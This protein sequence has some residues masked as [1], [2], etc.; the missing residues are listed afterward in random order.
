MNEVIYYNYSFVKKKIINEEKIEKALWFCMVNEDSEEYI[1]KTNQAHDKIYRIILGNK[2]EAANF[3]NK[4][5][6]LKKFPLSSKDIEKYST[7]FITND[8]KSK[9]SDIIYKKKGEDIFFLIEHQSSVDY[10]MAY[11]L[12]NY[13][14]EIIRSAIDEKKLGNKD[15][16]IPVVYPIVLYTGEKKWNAKKYLQEN[17]LKLK[18][19]KNIGITNYAITDISKC[20]EKDLM[21][22]KSF[23]SKILLLDKSRTNE[24][25]N[26]NLNKIIK[27]EM[28]NEEKTVLKQVIYYTLAKKIGEDVA[29]KYIE[30]LEY[31]EE[32]K[33][34]VFEEYLEKIIDEGLEKG[35]Q[36]GMKQGMKQ[37]IKEG[38]E[39]GKKENTYNIVIEMI[40]NNIDEAKIKL[41]TK[42][43][44]KEFQNIKA[45]MIKNNIKNNCIKTTN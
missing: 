3:I 30:K 41:I 26:Q 31:K 16:K 13:S 44:E 42:I 2:E 10:S 29:K 4:N 15:Y 9:E 34:S 14:I 8:F 35:M 33:M 27:I 28:T 6:K 1:L 19:C 40:K 12:L 21:E 17:Q 11:R 37:G 36:Q 5:L 24:S 38:I 39:K 32:E 7:K 23:L 25:I 20:G 22:E 43:S 18:E 45:N